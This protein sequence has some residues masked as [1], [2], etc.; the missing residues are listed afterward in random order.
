M[1]IP[2]F[3]SALVRTFFCPFFPCT[4]FYHSMRFL[5]SFLSDE[6]SKTEVHLPSDPLKE[7]VLSILTVFI[8]CVRY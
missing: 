5:A 6:P 1:G 2:A 3:F 7:L 4:H 8:Y